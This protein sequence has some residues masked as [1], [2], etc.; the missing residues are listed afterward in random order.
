MPRLVDCERSMEQGFRYRIQ[1]VMQ[2]RET[3]PTVA[4]RLVAAQRLVKATLREKVEDARRNMRL[5]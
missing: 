1:N 2:D 5:I 3:I 4:F